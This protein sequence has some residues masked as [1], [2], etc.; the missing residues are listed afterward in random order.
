MNKISVGLDLMQ[1]L[2]KRKTE[3]IVIRIWIILEIMMQIQI[4]KIEKMGIVE[5]K[6]KMI[7]VE[8]D[9]KNQERKNRL[10]DLVKITKIIKT[11][12]DLNEKN[13]SIIV[14]ETDSNKVILADNNPKIKVKVV[15]DDNLIL[16]MLN[17]QGLHKIFWMK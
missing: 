9:D 12:D 6:K 11:D 10:D 7:L 5:I 3:K 14:P 13:K 2:P 17:H 16:Q 4:C 15:D 1:L 8:I